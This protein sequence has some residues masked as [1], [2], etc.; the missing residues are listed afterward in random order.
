MRA[1]YK[2]RIL[3][4]A[5]VCACC[6]I[7]SPQAVAYDSLIEAISDTTSPRTY[8]LN[9][10]ETTYA[11]L[12]TMGGADATFTIDGGTGNYGIINGSSNKDARIYINKPTQTFNMQNV[13]SYTSTISDSIIAGKSVITD[14]V[15]MQ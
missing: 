13:G 2:N 15:V 8:T 1:K 3:F 5:I 6:I 4:S 11:V 9:A 14:V 12:G 10:N 7:N